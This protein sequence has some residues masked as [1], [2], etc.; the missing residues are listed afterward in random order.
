MTNMIKLTKPLLLTMTVCWLGVAPVV[1]DCPLADPA[2]CVYVDDDCVADPGTGTQADPFCRIQDAYDSVVLTTTPAMPATILVQA[3]TYQECVDA[4]STFDPDV[5]LNDDRPVHIVA[6]EWLIAGS[7]NPDPADATAFEVVALSTTIT[8]LGVCDGVLSNPRLPVVSIA[9]SEASIRGFTITQGGASGV[10]ARGGVDI[11][12]NLI[13]ENEGELGGGVQLITAVCAY[14]DLATV[15]DV[16]A[17]IT[18]NVVRNNVADDFSEAGRGDGGGIFVIADGLEPN[19]F[20]CAGGKSEVTVSDNVVA[21]GGGISVETQTE[22]PFVD[23][24]LYSATIRVCRNNVFGNALQAGV[25]GFAFG[26]GIFGSTLGFGIETLEIENNT[27]GPNN[28]IATTNGGSFG[29]GIAVAATPALFG[30]HELMVY[31]N[32][33]SQNTADIGAGLD[34]LAIAEDLDN[35]QSLVVTVTNNSVD[36]NI[37]LFE[38]GGVNAEFNSLRSLDAEDAANLFPFAPLIAAELTVALRGNLVTNNT[39]GTAGAGAVLRPDANADPLSPDF[40]IPGE[41]RPAVATI[42]FEGNYFEGNMAEA[43]AGFGGG[44]GC[45]DAVCESV[46]CGFDPFCCDTEW[47]QQC[48]DEAI[49]DE[50]TIG[51]CDCGASDC[52]VASAQ[53]V[54]GAGVLV[55]PTA[56]GESLAAVNMTTSTFVDNQMTADGFVGGVEVASLTQA[57]CFDF[58]DGMAQLNIE[59]CIVANN[60]ADGIGGPPIPGT[61]D[62]TVSVTKSSSFGNGDSNPNNDPDRDYEDTIFPGGAPAGN[63]LDDPLLDPVTFTPDLCSPVYDVGACSS[64]PDAVCLDDADCPGECVAEGAGYLASPDLNGD[65]AVDGVDVVRFS[66]AFGAEQSLDARYNPDA[67]VNRDGEIDGVDLPLIAPLFGQECIVP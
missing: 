21:G 52:C 23:P 18:N 17:T 16:I 26:A 30:I 57:D 61:T 39:S 48:A 27:V 14:G 6:D 3:G 46:I 47:D 53:D 49:D 58:F 66:L 62:L 11:S 43:V 37:S 1:A 35:D 54:I 45:S 28:P 24:E 41:Q 8:G 25:E 55:I 5:T 56:K 59:R 33:I 40:C 38:A 15:E 22:L 64:D 36:G 50:T 44:P 67:D 2:D 63:I 12:N 60:H 29:G 32:E 65:D 42:D 13:L 51:N 19:F 9:G 31:D 20:D 7:P 4:A 10:E 34:L